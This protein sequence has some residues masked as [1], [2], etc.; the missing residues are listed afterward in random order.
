MRTFLGLGL[1]AATS[2]IGQVSFA[3][4]W[5]NLEITIVY[6]GDKVPERKKLDMTKDPACMGAAVD[7]LL[8][9]NPEN[10]GIQNVGLWVDAKKSKLTAADIHPDLKEIPKNKLLLD[11]NKCV[12]IPHFLIARAGQTIEVKNSDNTGH[13]ANFNFLNNPPQNFVVPAGSSKDL[14]LEKG[15]EEPAAIPVQCNVHPWMEAK[16]M[17]L[18]HPYGAISDSNGVL[19]ME[20]VP[21]GKKLTFRI[22]H[23]N[24]AKSLDEFEVDGKKQEWKKG[25]NELELK[26]GDNKMKIKISAAKFKNK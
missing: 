10:K 18:D 14:V 24:Q 26:P 19:K 16:L 22:F 15:V 25:Y 17:V 20:K 2:L 11:N 23:E 3:Q 13:N 21:A 6:D 9:V 1:F 5:A 8:I 7:E 12:F 4:S